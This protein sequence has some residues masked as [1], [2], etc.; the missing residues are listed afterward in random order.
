MGFFWLMLEPAPELALST[1]FTYSCYD[2]DFDKLLLLNALSS[3]IRVL[4]A[5][6]GGV[7]TSS[8]FWLGFDAA[9]FASP[10]VFRLCDSFWAG[11]GDPDK[12]PF[13]PSLDVT[14]RNLLSFSSR[15]TF[16]AYCSFELFGRSSDPV[17]LDSDSCS[18][19]DT[20]LSSMSSS[21]P[22]AAALPVLMFNLLPPSLL[23]LC[24]TLTSLDRFF[25]LFSSPAESFDERSEGTSDSSASYVGDTVAAASA[26]VAA[27]VLCLFLAGLAD[28]DKFFGRIVVLARYRCGV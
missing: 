5:G 18:P 28:A 3:S 7:F 1:G 13:E 20:L 16:G 21:S 11:V 10:S 26:K 17:P 24:T 9:S 22:S 14:P 19:S 6:V 12:I 15:G 25:E 23:T 4:R 2:Y 27:G 8:T